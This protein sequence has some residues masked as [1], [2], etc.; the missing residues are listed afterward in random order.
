MEVSIQLNVRKKV[1]ITEVSP[2]GHIYVQIDTPEAHSLVNLSD[3]IHQVIESTPRAA[4]GFH[5]SPGT[6]CFAQSEADHLW[7]RA[8]VLQYTDTNN[9]YSVYYVDY[10]NKEDSLP[11][12][13]LFPPVTDF[14]A[15]PYQATKCSLAY[16]IPNNGG[17]WNKECVNSLRDNVLNQ[18]IPCVFHEKVTTNKNNSFYLITLYW[19]DSDED[20]TVAEELVAMGLGAYNPV[21]TAPC[22][23]LRIPTDSYKCINLT[24]GKT[25]Q[26]YVTV[27]ETPDMVWCQLAENTEIF[28]NL[29]INLQDAFQKPL[30]VVSDP[31]KNPPPLNE[32]CCVVYDLDNSWCR[33]LIQAVDVPSNTV[34][35]LFVDFGNTEVIPIS[36]VFIVPNGFLTIPAQAISFSLH[37]LACVDSAWSVEALDRFRELSA[38]F[39]LKCEVVC[40]DDNGYPSVRLIN[41]ALNQDI[42]QTLIMEGFGIQTR[43]DSVPVKNT[44]EEQVA[45]NSK[46]SSEE[47]SISYTSLAIPI[48]SKMD[49]SVTNISSMHSFHCQLYSQADQLTILMEQISNHCDSS[50]VQP[51][52]RVMP[53]MPVLAQFVQDNEWYR[54]YMTPPNESNFNEWGVV[55]VDYGN[56]Q[57]ADIGKLK[58]IPTFL[59]DI[60]TQSFHCSLID[61]PANI[62][63]NKNVLEVFRSLALD[64]F[65]QCLVTKKVIGDDGR[66]LFLVKIF[67]DG[68]NILKELL[69]IECPTVNDVVRSLPSL[70]FPVGQRVLVRVCY[71]ESVTNFAC[72]LTDNTAVIENLQIDLNKCYQNTNK[73]KQLVKPVIGTCCVA[74]FSEDNQWYRAIIQEVIIIIIIIQWNLSPVLGGQLLYNSH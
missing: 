73:V 24:V 45:I 4:N 58:Q 31:S 1:S 52:K 46:L 38:D 2:E 33:G 35:V 55:F 39:E 60:P 12:K 18:T 48:G 71:I 34:D 3:R 23:D 16:F 13:R 50:D 56:K 68:I 29:V 8:I 21:V 5:P 47:R 41:D 62:I 66:D 67:K 14:F 6:Q 32:P 63:N 11:I 40:L 19:D 17:V 22:P 43:Q 74:L 51:V 69:Q 25:Y 42:A 70:S 7:Y 10:G 30:P 57:G 65:I 9:S 54:A 53:G 44:K 37:G 15:M 28:E 26:V 72:Q 59:L 64:E 20:Y 61:C 49:A 27:A 36:N